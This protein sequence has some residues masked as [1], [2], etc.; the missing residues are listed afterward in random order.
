MCHL[1]YKEKSNT[2]E[3][4]EVVRIEE[5]KILD[6]YKEF[7]DEK[8]PLEK[9][10]LKKIEEDLKVGYI[11][12][13]NAIEGNT[14]TLK[15]TGV[16]L[17]YG[18]TVKGKPLKDHLEVKGQEYALQFLEEEIHNN[19]ELNIPL[20]KN[21]HSLILKMT[22]PNIAGIFKKYPNSIIGVKFETTSP[23]HV[24]EE[25]CSLVERYQ[26]EMGTNSIENI[27]KFH[28]D[29]EKIHPF[30]DGNGRTGRLIMNFELM[31]AG[32]PICIIQNEERLEYYD[33]LEEAQTKEDYTKII[34]FIEKSLLR[35]F[36]FYFK[37]LSTDWKKEI[38]EF[39][40]QKNL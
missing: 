4:V 16:I 35:T 6:L 14:L 40:K 28:A 39:K 1:V 13:S 5:K 22:D 25:L 2:M 32:Y 18:I 10:F 8:R 11:Y 20:I 33:A 7:L 29:F 12:N 9:N 23:F 24:E 15:E 21:F 34:L 31:K 37:H 19:S 36:E 26:K 3:K 17:E 38:E 30:S 27:A